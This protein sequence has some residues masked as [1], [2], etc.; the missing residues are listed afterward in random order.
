MPQLNR[1]KITL[2]FSIYFFTGKWNYLD[3]WIPSSGSW[4]HW[5]YKNSSM[6]FIKKG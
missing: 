1:Q 3:Q 5:E 6:D 2:Q 4:T